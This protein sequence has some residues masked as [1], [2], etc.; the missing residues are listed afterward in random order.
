MKKINCFIPFQDETQ[1]KTTV[2]NLKAQKHVDKIY[3]PSRSRR[4][5]CIPIGRGLRM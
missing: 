1:V 2:D 5:D 4:R 3:L